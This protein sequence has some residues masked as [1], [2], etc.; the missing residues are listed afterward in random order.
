MKGTGILV[1]TLVFQCQ[2]RQSDRGSGFSS[3][4]KKI[5]NMKIPWIDFLKVLYFLLLGY[6]ILKDFSYLLGAKFTCRKFY[7]DVM[8]L[9]QYDSE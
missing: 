9:D 8:S 7:R 4:L 3:P 5:S 1:G 2:T 6:A